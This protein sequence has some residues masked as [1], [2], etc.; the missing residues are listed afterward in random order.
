MAIYRPEQAQLTY[1]PEAAFGGDAEMVRPALQ[2]TTPFAGALTADHEAGSLEL[3]IDGVTNHLDNRPQV[4]DFV[5][6]NQDA[7]RDALDQ[8]YVE[9]FRAH[10]SK[11]EF[12]AQTVVSK[13]VNDQTI[14]N[15]FKL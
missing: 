2:G 9:I 3:T 6:K 10:P 8:K 15:L 12:S 1:G 13:I 14:K 11:T 5:V 4:G 7:M